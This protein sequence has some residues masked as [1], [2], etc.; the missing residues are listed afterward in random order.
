MTYTLTAAQVSTIRLDS[1]DVIEPFL[2]TYEEMALFYDQTYG[3]YTHTVFKVVRLM[4]AKWINR[5][6]RNG[7]KVG[8]AMY[9]ARRKE[10][11]ELLE[12]Y[13]AQAG[14]EDAPL[15]TSYIDMALDAEDPTTS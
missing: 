11:Y 14:V 6:P 15:S 3:D 2:V 9:D 4:C 13:K 12:F 1:T 8:M 5:R 7:D 10:L